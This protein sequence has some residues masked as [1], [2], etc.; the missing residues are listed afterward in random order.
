VWS[1]GASG[2]DAAS[3]TEAS[4]E[5]APIDGLKAPEAY[6]KP[7]PPPVEVP[8]EGDVERAPPA[9]PAPPP[10]VLKPAR[11]RARETALPAD[12]AARA[13]EGSG[14]GA[15]GVDMAWL[16]STVMRAGTATAQERRALAE[17]INEA[18]IRLGQRGGARQV[19][20][21]LLRFLEAGALSGLADSEGRSCRGRAVEALL[22]M[23]YPYALEISPEDLEHLRNES[24]AQ[25][26]QMDGWTVWAL[27]AAGVGSLVEF[28]R[29]IS[30]A[31]AKTGDLADLVPPWVWIQVGLAV[32][33]ALV[34][35][36]SGP[37][38]PVRRGGLGVLVVSALMGF[39]VFLATGEQE[40]VIGALGALVAAILLSRRE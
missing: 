16:R 30:P 25:G 21:F 33:G 36:F 17:Q 24:G 3:Q 19:A 15:A 29:S 22:A 4:P 12:D 11:P 32:I 5:V 9:A 26:G 34:A 7:P 6:L 2:S 14:S 40:P 13:N 39:V 37:A 38:S 35:A 20:D 28:A 27:G 31:A 1:G 18:F 23:G 8:V 10:K